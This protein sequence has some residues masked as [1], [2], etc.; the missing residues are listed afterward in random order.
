[1]VIVNG[2]QYK[3]STQELDQVTGGNATAADILLGK[4]AYV[5]GQELTGTMPSYT[6][7]Y[8]TN[9]TETENTANAGLTWSSDGSTLTISE[10]Y[11]TQQQ[12]SNQGGA[13]YKV[14]E[15]DFLNDGGQPVYIDVGFAPKA[16]SITVEPH[17]TAG[18]SIWYAAS[19]VDASG[20]GWY[21]TTS[22]APAGLPRNTANTGISSIDDNG[23]TCTAPLINRLYMST[24]TFHIYGQ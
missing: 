9:K 2:I 21:T 14:I 20:K 19:W 4:T 16:I 3:Y 22:A 10:G 12:V 1:W 18:G 7:Q 23:F 6:L 13:K 17:S 15:H 8:D 5:G 11:H 24:W